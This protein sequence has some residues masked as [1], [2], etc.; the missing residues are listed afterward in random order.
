MI[1]RRFGDADFLD[2]LAVSTDQ[3]LRHAVVMSAGNVGAGHV[4]IGEVE[5]VDQ[6]LSLEEVQDSVYGHRRDRVAVLGPANIRYLVG[7]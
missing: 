4:F 3:E 5:F 2:A 1:D 7:G 6:A